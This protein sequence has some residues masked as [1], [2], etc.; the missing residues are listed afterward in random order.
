MGVKSP[1]YCTCFVSSFF[2]S[3]KQY[4]AIWHI[5]S[6]GCQPGAKAE[7]AVPSRFQNL[8]AGD[9]QSWQ[10]WQAGHLC[11]VLWLPRR[12][13]DEAHAARERE[14]EQHPSG[15]A[16]PEFRVC[17]HHGNSITCS[18]G[19]TTR[20]GIS[21]EMTAALS[22]RQP[23]QWLQDWNGGSANHTAQDADILL[24]LGQACINLGIGPQ[25]GL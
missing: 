21:V 24:Y 17:E 3:A 16:A 23:V 15:A 25:T 18:S 12:C 11:P 4:S 1:K 7:A 22:R 14:G 6:K 19:P 10:G 5:L 20:L 9:R 8:C 13:Q 2:T